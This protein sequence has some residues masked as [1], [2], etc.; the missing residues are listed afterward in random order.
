MSNAA[1]DLAGTNPLDASSVLRILNLA[2]GNLLT[3]TS[4]SGKTYRVWAA[5]NV[6]TN[7]TLLSPNIGA[8]SS[9]TTWLDTSATSSSKFYRINVLR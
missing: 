7:F 5:T 9:T 2:D 1:E 6:G 4:V 8:T 3:W